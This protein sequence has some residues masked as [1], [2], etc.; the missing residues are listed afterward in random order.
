MTLGNETKMRLLVITQGEYGKRILENIRRY[1]PESW[2]IEEWSAPR[3]LPAVIDYP[4]DFLPA[5]MPPADLILSLGEHPGVAELLPDIA[6]ASGARAV[7]APV[8]RVDWLPRGLMNQL[9]RWLADRGVHAVFPKPFCTLTEE[10]YNYGKHRV[11]YHEPL[12]AEFAHYFGQPCFEVNC[13][14]GVIGQ[15]RTSRDAACGCARFVAERL[16]GTSV[17]SAE[18]E[19]GMLHHHYP[20]LASMGI[21]P[22]FHDT[23]MHISGRIMKE[24]IEQEIKTEKTPAPYFTPQGRVDA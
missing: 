12:V 8:D 17:D 24:A 16:P 13:Q 18:Q 2:T 14:D 23:I 21:D 10:S 20:C 11:E 22:D 15:V 6:T 4:E 5:Q 3:V 1:A 9:N 19:A 7:I